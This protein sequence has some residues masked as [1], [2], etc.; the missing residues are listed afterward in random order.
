[1]L[2][3]VTSVIVL[4]GVL[5][6][7][8]F[9]D[10]SSAVPGRDPRTDHPSGPH[11]V[12]GAGLLVLS[13]WCLGILNSHRKFFLS[14]TAPVLW[15][16]AMIATLLSSADATGEADLPNL[17]WG[18][19]AG[20]ALQFAVQLP[21]VLRLAR[22]LRVRLATQAEQ[23]REVVR[24]FVPVFISRGVVQISAYVD[25]YPRELAARGRRS[26]PHQRADAV[27][28]AGEL[29]RDGGLGGGIASHVERSGR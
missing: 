10:V 6:T 22:H 7:P 11:F 16:L 29:V 25:V 13:A 1:M 24:N 27:Y 2:A 3:L 19:V 12:S 8:I 17:A 14:Y 5:A 15:N 20:S 18:S 26:R 9:I 28:V 23:V 4:L 21:V